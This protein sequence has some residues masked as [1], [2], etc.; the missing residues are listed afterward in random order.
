MSDPLSAIINI[1]KDISTRMKEVKT[2]HEGCEELEKL[3]QQTLWI[4]EQFDTTC[5]D[6]LMTEA[7]EHLESALEEAQ[8]AVGKCCGSS[9]YS[10]L[11]R[12]K[13]HA[14][15]LKQASTKLENALFQIPLASLG[16]NA[17]LK[18]DI[19]ELS[20]QLHHARFEASAARAHQGIE[21]KKAIEEVHS[22]VQAKA[23]ETKEMLQTL[24]QNIIKNKEE[25]QVQMVLLIKEVAEA[26]KNKER[27]MEFELE[28]IIEAMNESM[29]APKK[30]Q[31]FENCLLCPI[32]QGVMRDP[33]ILKETG[34]TYDRPSIIEW[35][36]RGHRTDPLTNLELKSKELTPD[37][38]LQD[39]CLTFLGEP[40]SSSNANILPN[41]M[42][43]PLFEPGL[44]EGGGKL[45]I[46]S[47]IVLVSQ[48]LILGPYGGVI[49]YTL[50]ERKNKKVEDSSIEVGYG[51]WDDKDSMLVYEDTH[52]LYNGIIT[53]NNTQ[54]ETIINWKGKVKVLRTRNEEAYFD[55]SY[56]TPRMVMNILPRPSI[57]QMENAFLGSQVDKNYTIKLVVSL[58]AN[59]NVQ[60]WMWFKSKHPLPKF[61]GY[62]TNGEWSS[63]GSIKF[64]LS[65]SY[66]NIPF[67]SHTEPKNYVNT[68]K[69]QGC[70]TQDNN[71]SPISFNAKIA[72]C[73]SRKEL[74]KSEMS[75]TPLDGLESLDFLY[76]C[77]A[78]TPWRH[79]YQDPLRMIRMLKNPESKSMN[80]FIKVEVEVNYGLIDYNQLSHK[81]TSLYIPSQQN[82]IS[83]IKEFMVN[84][85]DINF[86]D[87]DGACLLYVASQQNSID[88]VKELIA[89]NANI[90]LQNKYGASPLHIASQSNSIDSV[91]ELLAR[92]VQTNLQD[93]N[94]WTPVHAASCTNS[95]NAIK[96]L[97]AKGANIHIQDNR[98][99]SPLHIASQQDS[100]DVIKEL[101]TN[102]A[103]INLQNKDEASPLY[104]AS[105]NNSINAVKMLIKKGAN[106]DQCDKDG[107]SPLHISSYNNHIDVVKELIVNNANIHL[108]A[109]NSWNSLHIA[110]KQNSI[111][112]V[113]EL[114]A[115]GANIH[116]RENND[117]TALHIASHE[118][119]SD[120]VKELIN[121]GA[122]VHLRVNDARTPMHIAAQKNSIDAINELIVGGASVDLRGNNAETPLHI[123]SKQNHIG[124]VKKLIDKK[125]NINLLDEDGACA[126]YIAAQ[127]N[128]VDVAKALIDNNADINL[129]D[130]EGCSPL[131]IASQQSFIDVVTALLDKGADVNLQ[132]KN[133]ASP[134]YTATQNN[135][136]DVVMEL[137]TNKANVNLQNKHGKSPLHIA[138]Q[139]NSIDIV[140]E[141][142]AHG[143]NVNLQTKNGS[144]P[145]YI[146]AQ[147]NSF[148]VVKELISHDAQVDLPSKD[149]WTSLH[150]A[151]SRGHVTIVEMLLNNKASKYIENNEGKNPFDVVCSDES[152]GPYEEDT[153][154]ELRTLLEIET[155]HVQ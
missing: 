97:T 74:P 31:E 72:Q 10:Q 120:V 9:I 41:E 45:V 124:V 91:K 17:D 43:V 127:K 16:T 81:R 57:Y 154:Q 84:V 89:Q 46:G 86:Q 152:F 73:S 38:V 63:N 13:E 78:S 58:Q 129:Q 106:I 37:Y 64:I 112:V 99:C 146:A 55:L 88:V 126:L 128:F 44:Y 25:F 77:E 62:I 93:I 114:I 11:V 56:K 49:G 8:E 53:L 34:T 23:R 69:I 107:W 116:L 147:E 94:G 80:P 18:A 102:G 28:Q 22:N 95:N 137:L 26:K 12:N 105:Q 52:Y 67:N 40:T 15:I 139:E 3:V 155:L 33:V 149:G 98:G 36:E 131:Y 1:V 29:R 42:I 21:L 110:S 7:L 134:L 119:S 20:H 75:S 71:A 32:S 2:N 48:T 135:S 68:Y 59:L 153:I 140:K 90:N 79:I 92:G 6:T 76:V 115:K 5:F 113:K 125:A 132:N 118:N 39:A 100:I 4:V 142:I 83:M 85:V 145:L 60:G 109:N 122:N 50:Y 24:V 27:E 104:V 66:G 144:S 103:N 143:A 35:F 121:Q 130:K 141:L 151:S 70:I 108:Q 87:K 47:S 96:E 117:W 54:G 136:I 19:F 65:V 150:V 133:G 111:D 14:S 138:S 123:A 148:D 101:I 61:V 51:E 30:F 82:F